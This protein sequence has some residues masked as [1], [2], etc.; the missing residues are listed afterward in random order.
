MNKLTSWIFFD[1][2]KSN[3]CS[4]FPFAFRSLHFAYKNGLKD[5]KSP[6]AMFKSF[7]IKSPIGKIYSYAQAKDLAEATGLLSSA[8]EI[9]A[10]EFKTKK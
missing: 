4:S 5:G 2:A 1:G 7:Y 9:N 8:G 6:A 3:E 10:K